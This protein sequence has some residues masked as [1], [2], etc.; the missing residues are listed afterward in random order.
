MS[1]CSKR[2]NSKLDLTP[3]PSDTMSPTDHMWL[4]ISVPVIIVSVLVFIKLQQGRN[5]KL[6]NSAFQEKTNTKE[7][8]PALKTEGKN[9]KEHLQRIHETHQP[10]T[11]T[12]DDTDKPSDCPHYLGYLYMR[13]A[14]DRANIPSECYNCRRL[15]RCLYSPNVIEKVYGE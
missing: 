9:S 5:S 2:L 11:K 14:P 12:V 7:A 13:K 4:Y 15:L 10:E 6:V 8:H 3:R 1:S